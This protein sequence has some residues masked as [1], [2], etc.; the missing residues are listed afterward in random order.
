MEGITGDE[1]FGETFDESWGEEGALG[2]PE[3]ERASGDMDG[4]EG[5]SLEVD[6]PAVLN[7]VFLVVNLGDG[8]LGGGAGPLE[9][10]GAAVGG[11]GKRF[12][13]S[14][15]LD[16][17][18]AKGVAIPTVESKTLSNFSM[19]MMRSPVAMGDSPI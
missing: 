4:E 8:L 15:D 6:C 18:S 10:A 12:A 17:P 9:A 11:G 5:A 7:P 3:P 1:V 14:D 2:K 19:N 16:R 13:V